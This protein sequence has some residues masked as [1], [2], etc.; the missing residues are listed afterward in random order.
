MADEI[1]DLTR[2]ARNIAYPNNVRRIPIGSCPDR[3]C[4]GDLVALIRPDGD[5]PSSEI[6]CTVSAEHSWPITWWTK[7]A[8][9]IRVQGE[10]S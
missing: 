1:H 3:D 9:Q 8:R 4:D 7:L 5:I 2:V 10:S 6:I